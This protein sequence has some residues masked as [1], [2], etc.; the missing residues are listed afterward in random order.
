MEE[1][2]YFVEAALYYGKS[3]NRGRTLAFRRFGQAAE[4]IRFA[5]EELTPS[6]LNGCKLEIGEAEYFGR[7]IR[8]LYDDSAFP[9][10]RR[11]RASRRNNDTQ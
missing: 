10:S 4:A 1:K 5:V 6:I 9:L 7:A 8:P 11:K 3:E 2:D